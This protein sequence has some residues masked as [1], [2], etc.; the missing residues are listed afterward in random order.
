MKASKHKGN[1]PL[2]SST[3]N[4]HA[5]KRSYISPITRRILAINVLALALLV[6]GLL[7]AGQYREGLIETEIA[8]LNVQAELFATALGEAAVG[9]NDFNQAFVVEDA[10]QIV[11]RMIATTGTIAQLVMPNG[12][13]L[14][15]SRLF[16]GPIRN[17]QVKELPPP[18]L[19]NTL[20]QEASEYLE[21]ILRFISL[22]TK[23]FS[24]PS[25]IKNIA[26]KGD[27]GVAINTLADGRLKLSVAVP[28]QHYKQILGAL[29]LTKDGSK[30]DKT[31]FQVRLDI[32]K[33]FSVVLLVTILLSMYLASSI[34]RPLKKLAIGIEDI[35]R[36]KS[37]SYD[38]ADILIRTDEIGELGNMLNDMT[39]ALWRRM[40]AIER[41]AA[42]V[43]HEIKNPL[44]SL[45][46]AIE[47]MASLNS[48]KKQNKLMKII[49]DDVERL[50]RLISD[51]SDASRLD[52]ELS[53]VKMSPIELTSLLNNLIGIYDLT[54]ND[55]HIRFKLINAVEGLIVIQGVEDRI[56]QVLRNL[57]SN[58]ISFSPV[59]G[60]IWL[61]TGFR[62]GIV[63]IHV[64]DEGPGLQPGTEDSVFE[65]FYRERPKN[66]KFGIHSGLGLSISQQIILAHGGKLSAKNLLDNS[67]KILGACFTIE[68]PKGC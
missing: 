21:N 49:L 4:Q 56:V 10:K 38:I 50:D 65:R 22:N 61:E 3:L 40:E 8:A 17:V 9:E 53:R 31:V 14:I 36:G 37:Q 5:K 63:N 18:K 48:P 27:R 34:A 19:E 11:R 55:N 2:V 25:T 47:T 12:D 42:D 35:R 28:I 1:G 60:T 29:L 26:L 64:I 15:D 59:N 45:R 6:L 41:F 13:L 52:S 58:A 30:I 67:G 7:Y 16:R 54:D 32:L 66:E 20:G 44:T 62:D 23:K 43:S 57:I 51:I 68:L 39:E 46:S 24:D 33:V